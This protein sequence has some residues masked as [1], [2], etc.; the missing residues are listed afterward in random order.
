MIRKVSVCLSLFVFVLISACG[1]GSDAPGGIVDKLYVI[2]PPEKTTSFMKDLS[3][4]VKNHGMVPKLGQ[5]TD[6]KGYSIYVLDATS[7]SVRLRSENV[8]LS[9]HED[10]EQCG[11]YNEPHSDPGQYFISVSPAIQKVDSTDS[12]DLLDKVVRE[13]EADGYIVQ[14]EPTTCSE[15][16]KIRSGS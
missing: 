4:I 12:R 15:Q 5:A 3:F 6:D 14:Q 8:L 11:V 16:S 13:L 2:A 10:P 1:S 9:G 7:P